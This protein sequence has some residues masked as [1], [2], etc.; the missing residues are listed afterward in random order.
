MLKEEEEGLSI[1]VDDRK[2]N[3]GKAWVDPWRNEVKYSKQ[4]CQ[5]T[6]DKFP[7]RCDSGGPEVGDVQIMLDAYLG[8]YEEWFNQRWP[9]NPC[10]EHLYVGRKVS[11]VADDEYSLSTISELVKAFPVVEA[12]APPKLALS[13]EELAWKAHKSFF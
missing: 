13:K 11:M 2:I 12:P 1:L 5:R 10:S 4:I 7:I 9:E 8:I 6:L 3:I